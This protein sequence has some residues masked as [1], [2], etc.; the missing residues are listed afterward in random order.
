MLD[1][2]NYHTFQPLLYQ[3]ATAGLEPDSISGPLRKSFGGHKNYVFRMVKV[4]GLDLESKE[5]ITKVGNLKYDYLV[6]VNGSVTNYFG[7]E[8]FR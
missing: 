2:N 7:K 3:V 8:N 6:I 5:V 1:R 4:T